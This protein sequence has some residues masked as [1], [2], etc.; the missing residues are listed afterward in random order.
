MYKRTF[1]KK[2]EKNPASFYSRS[3]FVKLVCG[4]VVISIDFT[5]AYLFHG[6]KCHTFMEMALI[7]FALSCGLFAMYTIIIELI[8]NLL[9]TLEA[10]EK[11]G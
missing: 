4:F 6:F 3:W 2:I 5:L 8:D 11:N 7:I 9:M 1:K 10:I